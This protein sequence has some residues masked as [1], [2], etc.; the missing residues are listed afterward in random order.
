MSSYCGF[1]ELFMQFINNPEQRQLPDRVI[2]ANSP[3]ALKLYAFLP[4]KVI[5][6]GGLKEF[7]IPICCRFRLATP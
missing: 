5:T 4:M 1:N 3:I 2:L 7:I 6:A